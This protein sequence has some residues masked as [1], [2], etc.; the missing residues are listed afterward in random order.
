M[1]KYVLLT[2]V[3]TQKLRDLREL[4]LLFIKGHDGGIYPVPKSMGGS[5]MQKNSGKGR[6]LVQVIN[7]GREYGEEE[8]KAR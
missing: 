5:Q 2:Q 6:M 4:G 8:T 7:G 3:S 1:A